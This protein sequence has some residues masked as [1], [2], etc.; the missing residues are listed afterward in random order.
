MS[1]ARFRYWRVLTGRLSICCCV[2]TPETSPL[3]V[4]IGGAS[5][6]T[7]ISSCT[8]P[9][10]S[11]TSLS[12]WVPTFS[13]IPVTLAL[14]KPGTSVL[15]EYLPVASAGKR[16]RPSASVTTGRLTPDSS[17]PNDSFTA[18]RS[19]PPR[20]APLPPTSPPPTLPHP[21]AHTH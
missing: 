10:V 9:T 19:L 12:K 5:A 1:S 7:V 20:S 13:T 11:A 8:F 16:Y 18:P 6:V 2:T 15:S 3:L 4:S 17:L 21:P 14:R